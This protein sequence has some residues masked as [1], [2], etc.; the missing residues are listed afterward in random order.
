MKVMQA[1]GYALMRVKE[2]AGSIHGHFTK[3][4][5]TFSLRSSTGIAAAFS[6]TNTSQR[7]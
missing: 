5:R 7:L 6:P 2:Q 3:Q 1:V 4:T